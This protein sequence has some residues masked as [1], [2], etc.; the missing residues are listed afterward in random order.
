MFSKIIRLVEL[1]V[2]NA[3]TNCL[4]KG[5]IVLV[6]QNANI[7]ICARFE[8][9]RSA[10]FSVYRKKKVCVCVCSEFRGYTRNCLQGGVLAVYTAVRGTRWFSVVGRDE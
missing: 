5:H 2:R 4:Y 3:I 8:N 1:K 10:I 6:G 9:V 7:L